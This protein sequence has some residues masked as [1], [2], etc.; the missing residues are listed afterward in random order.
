MYAH[1]SLTSGLPARLSR[2]DVLPR[3]G[4]G[5]GAVGSGHACSPTPALLGRRTTA[6]GG[7]TRSP[8]SRRTSRRGPSAS[9]S[10]S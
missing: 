5:F 1:Q 10:C 9:S 7:A 4:G 3:I 8:P 2:R 6:G